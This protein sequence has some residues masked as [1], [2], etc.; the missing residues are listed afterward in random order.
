MEEK[1]TNYGKIIVITLAVIAGACAIA[2]AVM[3]L[4]RKFFVVK[5]AD[6]DELF[7]DEE[8]FLDGEIEIDTDEIEAAPEADAEVAEA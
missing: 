1:K 7:F 3:K 8:D 4:Y 5:D 6:E 2:Y